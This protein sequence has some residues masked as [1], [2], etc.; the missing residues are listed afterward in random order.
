[1]EIILLD[2]TFQEKY[3]LDVFNSL[4]WTDRYWVAGD[5]E[6]SLL[7]ETYLLSI[8][9]NIKYLKLKE[10]EHIMVFE[11]SNIH[12]DVEKGYSLILK[13]ESLESIL[14]RRVIWDP[15]T[16][17]G[18]LQNGIETILNDSFIS[19]SNNDRKVNHFKFVASTDPAITSLTI[20]TQ[21]HGEYVYD[22][23]ENICKSK[24]IGFKITLSSLLEMEFRLYAGVDRSFGQE[25]NPFVVF[26]PNYDNLINSDYVETSKFLKTEILVAGEQGVGNTRITTSASAPSGGTGLNRREMFI[27]SNATRNDPDGELTLPEYISLLQEQ[28]KQALSENIF[29]KAFD[30]EVDTT[31][32]NYGDDFYMGDVLQIADAFGHQAD[33]RVIEMIYSQDKSGIRMYPTFAAE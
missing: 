5:Y 29:I 8:L 9:E 20:D 19:P 31:M 18:S 6:I 26:S 33:S 11:S 28:G 13:G 25:T 7:P 23:I 12:S 27:V 22:V 16:L 17:N 10:S 24:K 15:I 32:Y 21:Y 4:I 3:I 14:K 30:G 2:N 1:M